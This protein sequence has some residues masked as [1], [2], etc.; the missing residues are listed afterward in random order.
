M[1]TF[2]VTITMAAEGEFGDDR[3]FTVPEAVT[4]SATASAAFATS[5]PGIFSIELIDLC[6][7]WDLR[8]IDTTEDVW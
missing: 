4:F 6:P 1:T 2:D 3:E 8:V 7:T 5:E